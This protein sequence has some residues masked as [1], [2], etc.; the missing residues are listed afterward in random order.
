M[1]IISLKKEI[2]KQLKSILHQNYHLELFPDEDDIKVDYT[3]E[4]KLN[5]AILLSRTIKCVHFRYHQYLPSLCSLDVT[6]AKIASFVQQCDV[7]DRVIKTADPFFHSLLPNP[8]D[9]ETEF[10]AALLLV[11]NLTYK[12][13]HPNVRGRLPAFHKG[14]LAENHD[15]KYEGHVETLEVIDGTLK[16]RI[17][18]FLHP[19]SY[20]HVA[21]PMTDIEKLIKLRKRKRC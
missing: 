16:F 17:D 4:Q 7:L 1:S 3:T 15:F 8:G 11:S 6:K 14:L 19:E 10:A 20:F 13:N 18:S 9:N 12:K 21:I 5:T 2:V